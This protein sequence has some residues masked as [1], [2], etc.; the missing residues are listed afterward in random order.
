MD[1]EEATLLWKIAILSFVVGIAGAAIGGLFTFYGS[2][3]A[4]NQ[5]QQALN[6]E[7]IIEQ[8]NIAHAIYIDVSNIEERFNRSMIALPIYLNNN[9]SKWNDPNFIL[10]WS[11]QY[12]SDCGLFYVFNKD[13]SRFDIV[14]SEDL[15]EFYNEVADIEN[16]REFISRTMDKIQ[17]GE[18]VAQYDLVT[19]HDY[20]EALF[21]TKIPYSIKQAEKIKQEI[22]QKYHVKIESPPM[23]IYDNQPGTFILQNGYGVTGI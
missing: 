12:Y 7:Q 3:W 4:W 8:K 13:I 6:Q 16:K 19:A 14:T 23:I 10:S 18:P 17:H 22:R 11:T 21:G 1:R 15:Y 5:Q 20:T 9:T 2:Y